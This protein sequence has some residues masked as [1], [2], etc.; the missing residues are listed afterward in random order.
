MCTIKQVQPEMLGSKYHNVY[1]V[2]LYLTIHKEH[3]ITST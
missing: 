3:E 2:L 1:F